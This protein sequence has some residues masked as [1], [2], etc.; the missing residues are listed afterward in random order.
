MHWSGLRT[1][2]EEPRIAVEANVFYFSI[3]FIPCVP[4]AVYS[5]FVTGAA[6]YSLDM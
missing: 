2:H 3:V 5:D 1:I 4:R 6:A